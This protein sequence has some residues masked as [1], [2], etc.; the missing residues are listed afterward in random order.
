M[1]EDRDDGPGQ[2]HGIAVVSD[3]ERHGV[4]SANYDTNERENPCI[5]WADDDGQ[6]LRLYQGEMRRLGMVRSVNV[7]LLMGHMQ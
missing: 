3:A 4:A 7:H 2:G 6:L 5:Q 1:V